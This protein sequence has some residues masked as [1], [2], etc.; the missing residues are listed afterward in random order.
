MDQVIRGETVRPELR[1]SQRHQD[2]QLHFN[3]FSDPAQKEQHLHTSLFQAIVK[4][5]NIFILRRKLGY[6]FQSYRYMV[7][8]NNM[9]F[10]CQKS[11]GY[12][13]CLIAQILL[14]FLGKGSVRTNFSNF[15]IT[16]IWE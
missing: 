11:K 13:V 8:S 1:G 15:I 5:I 12:S 2:G 7:F 6:N 4:H 10:G 14:S 3:V 16:E 9:S